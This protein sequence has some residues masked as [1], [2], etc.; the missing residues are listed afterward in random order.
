MCPNMPILRFLCEVVTL[1]ESFDWSLI[2]QYLFFKLILQGVILTLSLA[3]LA[4]TFGSFIGLLLYFLRRARLAPLR[5]LANTYIWFFRGTP[6]LL[7]IL[8]FYTI[9]PYLGLLGPL[10]SLNFF[11]ALGFTRVPM[12]SFVAALVALSL[13]EG[14]YMAE[15]VRAGIDAI[16][17]GQMEAAKSL[18]MT[19]Y[20][21]MRRIVLPQAARVIV[22]PLGNEFNSML[23]NTSLASSI[24]LL[25]LV[26]TAQEIGSHSFTTLELLVVASFWFL[27]LTTIW[28]I[29][30]AY[31]ERRL[32]VSVTDPGARGPGS[33]LSRL[34]GFNFGNR[35]QSLQGILTR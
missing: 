34:M 18:G 28:T 27:F 12:D 16:D 26:G 21:A 35:D 22:P 15:I 20:K 4:Q 33:Y 17:V 13:N 1:R 32:N 9:I 23:K 19:Y 5:W 25:E 24:A 11:P 7:Q 31:I 6:L 8:L 3:I 29:I 2:P 10:S 14:A 30:Q